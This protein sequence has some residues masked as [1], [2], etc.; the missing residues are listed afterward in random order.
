MGNMITVF[1]RHVKTGRLFNRRIARSKGDE[2]SI[3][4][5]SPSMLHSINVNGR[6]RLLGYLETLL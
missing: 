2:S 5:M 3:A 1:E 6:G 4:P